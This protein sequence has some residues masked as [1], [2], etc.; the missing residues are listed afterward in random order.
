MKELAGMVRTMKDM[1]EERAIIK[2]K[3]YSMLLTWIFDYVSIAITRGK[4]GSDGKT[5]YKRLK[6]KAPPIRSL[7]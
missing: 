6:E 4:V 5:A 2:L 7:R 3:D 1:V